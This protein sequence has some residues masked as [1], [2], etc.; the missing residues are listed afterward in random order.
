MKYYQMGEK[1]SFTSKELHTKEGQIN[2]KICKFIL[3]KM[4]IF[5]NIIQKEHQ[6]FA[7]PTKYKF[8]TKYNSDYQIFLLT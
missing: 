8:N 2:I 4:N 6:Q 5:K 1:S 7:L 3:T